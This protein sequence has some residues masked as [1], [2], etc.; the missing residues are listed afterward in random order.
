MTA[1]KVG[2]K[3]H[4]LEVIAVL[5]NPNGTISYLWRCD[6]GVEFR[7]GTKMI[8][9]G[10]TKSCG[11]LRR[12]MLD[13]GYAG[14]QRAGRQ[15]ESRRG[16]KPGDRFGRLVVERRTDDVANKKGVLYQAICDCGKV[17][18]RASR[19][20]HDTSSCG[21]Y[22]NEISR[23]LIH[24]A[25]TKKLEMGAALKHLNQNSQW[26]GLFGTP[27]RISRKLGKKRRIVSKMAEAEA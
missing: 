12:E 13:S 8:V 18:T 10:N 27:H 4:R 26:R 22:R 19:E 14:K 3:F 5:K 1:L 21:C 7:R 17:V 16:I 20:F 11:C 25:R 9:G 2:D 24:K 15:F 23:E 6:C